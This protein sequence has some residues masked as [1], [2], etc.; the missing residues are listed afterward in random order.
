M[1]TIAVG[2]GRTN[3]IERNTIISSERKDLILIKHASPCG[4]DSSPLIWTS[5]ALDGWGR[6]VKFFYS[7]V[8]VINNHE[9]SGLDRKY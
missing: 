1:E 2:R 4:V 5:G 7:S 3:G 8:E 9:I 6:G